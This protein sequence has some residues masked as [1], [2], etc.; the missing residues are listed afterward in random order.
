MNIDWSEHFSERGRT[1]RSSAI[2]ELLK[3]TELPDAIS[4]AGGF[5]APELFPIE[6]FRAAS[7]KV[8]REN[9]PASLQYGATEGYRP[10]REFVAGHLQQRGM[11]FTTDEV[12]ITA[13]SQQ[14]LDLV[15]K[16]FIDEGDAVVVENPSYVGGLQAFHMFGPKYVAVPTDADGLCTN[17]LEAALN[18]NPKF[19]YVLPNFQNP[20]GST[21]TLER[22]RAVAEIA[23]AHGVPI[24]E[25]DPYAELMFE[26]EPLPAITS[27]A[28]KVRGA[29]AASM[30]LGTFSKTLAPGLRLGWIA[31]PAEV[32]RKVVQLKQ[33]T[34]LH[35][36]TFTQMVAYEIARTGFIDKHVREIRKV[37]HARMVAMSEAL[38]KYFPTETSWKNPLGGMFLWVRLPDGVDSR[39]VLK[40]AVENKVAFVPGNAFFASGDTGFEYMRLNFSNSTPSRIEEGV[41]RLGSAVARVME[42]AGVTAASARR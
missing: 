38:K 18:D 13:G 17:H 9:G 29:G 11:Q 3:V 35:T 34:D 31:A 12:I 30:H 20:S 36:S 39:E 2:R 37:Y 7:D 23:D 16:L 10:L 15:G 4:F 32:T 5:P 28:Q 26:G 25:D 24:V 41:R 27:I 21:L 6:Q 19:I 33:G 1:V 14:A 40:I 8:L 22:R 42:A